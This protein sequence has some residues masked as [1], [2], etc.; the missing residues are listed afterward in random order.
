VNPDSAGGETGSESREAKNSREKKKKR[1][2]FHMRFGV[3]KKEI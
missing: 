1:K 2:K 3:L